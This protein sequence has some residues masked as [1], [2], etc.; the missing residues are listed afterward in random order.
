ML[1]ARRVETLLD[2]AP[3][4]IQALLQGNNLPLLVA[5]DQVHQGVKVF[6]GAYLQVRDSALGLNTVGVGEAALLDE[7]AFIDVGLDV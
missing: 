7:R 2:R 1:Q 3:V 5:A 6:S 4:L